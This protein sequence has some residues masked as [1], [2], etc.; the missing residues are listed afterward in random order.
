MNAQHLLHLDFLTVDFLT[1]DF[2]T[3]VFLMLN[4]LTL[5]F[6]TPD[7]ITQ[8]FLTQYSSTNAETSISLFLYAG[9]CDYIEKR[10]TDLHFQ[11]QRK[12]IDAI[13][14]RILR[15]HPDFLSPPSPF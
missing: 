12:L 10:Y 11:E 4:F 9:T 6:L 13:H 3:L 2:L 7:F 15:S 5:V 1:L 8:D 14:E